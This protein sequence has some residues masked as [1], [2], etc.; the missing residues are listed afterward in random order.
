M[1]FVNNWYVIGDV[2]FIFDVFYLLGILMIVFVIESVIEIICVKLVGEVDV[3]EKW[4][5][6][7]EYN[8]IFVNIVNIFVSN[9]FY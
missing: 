2:V 6:Y 4:V 3:E 1:F 8:F 7:N 9:Y 5:V